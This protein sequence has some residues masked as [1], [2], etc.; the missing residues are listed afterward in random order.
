MFQRR[1]VSSVE[2]HEK[3]TQ[4]FEGEGMLSAILSSSGV[5]AALAP[6]LAGLLAWGREAVNAKRAKQKDNAYYE[7]QAFFGE[8]WRAETY[9]ELAKG[10]QLV[11][12]L[13]KSVYPP[14]VDS[15]LSSTATASGVA[16]V[17]TPLVLLDIPSTANIFGMLTAPILSEGGSADRIDPL[18]AVIIAAIG[19]GASIL[20]RNYLLHRNEK[21]RH[22][23]IRES[24]P[25]SQYQNRKEFERLKEAIFSQAQLFI[26]EKIMP[27]ISDMFSAAYT[28]DT[29]NENI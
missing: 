15:K 5:W 3:P 6:V 12:L 8:G 1:D 10:L 11:E 22:Q 16:S 26:N 23:M 7:L 13:E 17:F 19:A 24:I 2:Y 21:K 28:V 27:E 29:A 9:A 14:S 18:A 4:L 20:I 25:R